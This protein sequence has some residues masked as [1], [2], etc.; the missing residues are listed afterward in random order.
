MEGVVATADALATEVWGLPPDYEIAAR[1]EVYRQD[2]QLFPDDSVRNLD[3]S[4]LVILCFADL[5]AEAFAKA[6]ACVRAK[7][8][9]EGSTGRRGPTSDSVYPEH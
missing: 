4:N 5:S 8:G 6:E 2:L 1:I 3:S 9:V 7:A